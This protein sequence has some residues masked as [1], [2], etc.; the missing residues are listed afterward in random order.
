M[1]TIKYLLNQPQKV[2]DHMIQSER[3][4]KRTS[5]ARLS[6]CPKQKLCCLFVWFFDHVVSRYTFSFMHTFIRW[7]KFS[8]CSEFHIVMDPCTFCESLCVTHLHRNQRSAQ[9]WFTRFKVFSYKSA[10]FAVLFI[11]QIIDFEIWTSKQWVGRVESQAM[12]VL[13]FVIAMLLFWFVWCLISYSLL[14]AWL[15]AVGCWQ[16]LLLEWNCD[17]RTVKRKS[18]SMHFLDW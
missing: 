11:I 4:R 13:D 8:N 2:A 3:R 5:H 18:V 16:L 17:P 14:V 10:I 7:P 1:L 12:F 9:Q 6:S 15:L